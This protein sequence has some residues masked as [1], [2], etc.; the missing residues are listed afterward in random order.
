MNSNESSNLSAEFAA[1]LISMGLKSSQISKVEQGL[2]TSKINLNKCSFNEIIEW[3]ARNE[4]GSLPERQEDVNFQTDLKKN[5]STAVPFEDIQGLALQKIRFFEELLDEDSGSMMK[6]LKKELCSMK[7]TKSEVHQEYLRV[8]REEE[9]LKE[10][11]FRATR[12]II[13]KLVDNVLNFRGKKS[14]KIDIPSFESILLEVFRLNLLN[15]NQNQQLFKKYM[16][17]IQKINGEPNFEI[18]DIIENLSIKG[19]P[20]I[21]TINFKRKKANDKKTEGKTKSIKDAECKPEYQ[22]K[23][24]DEVITNEDLYERDFRDLCVI[25]LNK[26]REIVYLPCAHLLTCNSCGPLL[27][28]CPICTQKVVSKLKIYWS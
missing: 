15:N 7:K 28:Q 23:P 8:L 22:N 18:L 24:T 26:Q 6:L 10:A 21:S 11:C 3:A 20:K 4:I 12:S 2:I 9:D 13:F 27:D 5:F 14:I 19:T 25:C 16:A 1:S 17:Y